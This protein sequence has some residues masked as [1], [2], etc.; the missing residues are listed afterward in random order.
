MKKDSRQLPIPFST[1]FVPVLPDI[2]RLPVYRNLCLHPAKVVF[3]YH[4]AR[5]GYFSPSTMC[6]NGRY[7]SWQV[8]A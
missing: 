6:R 3:D 5:H 1:S 7:S 8:A 4:K 2:P